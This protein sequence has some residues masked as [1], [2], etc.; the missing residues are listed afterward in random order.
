MKLV[1]FFNCCT[2]LSLL[3]I[4]GT[5][6]CQYLPMVCAKNPQQWGIAVC[7]GNGFLWGHS[8]FW[9][10]HGCV[11]MF[12][13]KH[14]PRTRRSSYRLRS[15]S[16]GWW[17]KMT[18]ISSSICD[19]SLFPCCDFKCSK[20]ISQCWDVT[21]QVRHA[22]R[23]NSHHHLTFPRRWTCRWVRLC[24]WMDSSGRSV[25]LHLVRLRPVSIYFSRRGRSTRIRDSCSGWRP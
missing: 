6:L 4:F 19:F 22:L 24:T 8:L 11:R 23:R 13:V 12:V 1:E 20:P 16:G 15:C 7:G 2:S 14:L 25:H 21:R 17:V 10:I 9:K 5:Q 18:N 3:W